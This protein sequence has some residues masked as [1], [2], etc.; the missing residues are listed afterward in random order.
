MKEGESPSHTCKFLHLFQMH[1]EQD[2]KTDDMKTVIVLE[3]EMS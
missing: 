3:D 1:S 2:P